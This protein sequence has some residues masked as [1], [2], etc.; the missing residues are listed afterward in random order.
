MSAGRRQRT[1]GLA[2]PCVKPF[3][4]PREAFRKQR[5]PSIT[6]GQTTGCDHAGNL[7]QRG[8]PRSPQDLHLRDD[9]LGGDAMM[10]VVTTLLVFLS[11]SVFVAHAFDAYRAP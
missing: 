4:A 1:G 2:P 9:K 8:L 6:F 5:R 3:W 11:V 7:P 10:D